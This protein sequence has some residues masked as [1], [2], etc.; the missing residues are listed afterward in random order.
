MKIS[1]GHLIAIQPKYIKAGR[2]PAFEIYV[3]NVL[4]FK[5]F[6]R[7]VR[8]IGAAFWYAFSRHICIFIAGV[9]R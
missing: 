8:K 2:N 5:I 7:I 9:K 3:I 4:N 6:C 1:S